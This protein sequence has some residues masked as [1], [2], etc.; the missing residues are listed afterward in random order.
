MLMVY[1]FFFVCF[2]FLQNY[3]SINSTTGSVTVHDSADREVAQEYNIQITVRDLNAYDP[4]PQTATSKS[5]ELF[6][7]YIYDRL[8]IPRCCMILNIHNMKSFYL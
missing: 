8:N 1:F 6:N 2:L 5:T 3:F 4:Y 7:C